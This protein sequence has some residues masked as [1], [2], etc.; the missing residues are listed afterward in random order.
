MA[1]CS[2][3]MQR[4]PRGWPIALGV[5][6]ALAMTGVV[7]TALPA[8]AATDADLRATLQLAQGEIDFDLEP[9]VLQSF[10]EEGVPFFIQVF[11]GCAVNGHYW[12]FAAGLGS[13]AVPLE[14]VDDRSEQSFRSVLPAY[15]PGEAIGTVFEPEA[16]A[17]CRDTPSGGLPEVAATATYTSVTPRCADGT[18]RFVLLS[19]GS[20]D[21]FREVVR[22]ASENDVIFSHDPIAIRDRSPDVDELFLLAE[23]RTP[24]RVEGVRF[25]GPQGML[26][27]ATALERSVKGLTRARVRRA[28]EAAK[29]QLVPDQ[30]IDELGLSR[31]DCIFHVALDV[32]TP[33]GPAYLAEA[34][35]IRE[36]GPAAQPPQLVEPRFD[37]QLRHADGTSE[38]LP[39]TGP[40]QGSLG[41]GTYWEYASDT[42]KVRILDGCSL[43]GAFW[44]IAAAVTDEPLELVV[45]DTQTGNSLDQVLWTDREDVSRLADTASLA[46]L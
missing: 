24:G 33:G 36:G 34:G 29:V 16:L 15:V 19:N 45:T 23:G 25:S 30:L 32:D 6:F 10:D 37:V 38:S 9:D 14:V 28:F 22:G 40:W 17:I 44:T 27:R 42:A 31:V 35:W 39:L 13:D 26:P 8:A 7:G 20:P 43:G 21:A 18:D 41:E 46:C 11:D 4:S 12:V 3:V 5:T 2:T 1:A